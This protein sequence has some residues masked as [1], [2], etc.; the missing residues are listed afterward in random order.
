[1]TSEA[2]CRPP[3]SA[4]KLNA[5]CE[6]LA[7]SSDP[8]DLAA[9][10]VAGGGDACADEAPDDLCSPRAPPP[11]L[12][13]PA[14][15]DD[16]DDERPQAAL[17]GALTDDNSDDNEADDDAPQEPLVAVSTAAASSM[18]TGTA[19]SEV[20]CPW[21]DTESALDGRM[22]NKRKNF[23]PKNIAAAVFAD[24]DEEEEEDEDED[25][26]ED[27][28]QSTQPPPPLLLPS[29]ADVAQDDDGDDEDDDGALSPSAC[30][31][32][33]TASSVTTPP[34]LVPTTCS[35]GAV[36][37]AVREEGPLDLSDCGSTRRKLQ[38]PVKRVLFNS[39]AISAEGGG[40]AL[41]RP[42][43]FPEAVVDLSGGSGS[44]GGGGGG[45]RKSEDDDDDGPTSAAED[46]RS[47]ASLPSPLRLQA[48][49]NE[50][51]VTVGGG[52]SHFVGG[53]R[54]HLL[55]HHH[56]HHHQH[57]QLP[58][59]QH[60]QSHPP[61][62][63]QQQQQPPVQHH[64]HRAADASLM[65]DYAENTMKEL[66]SMYGLHDV[67]ESITKHVPLH[68]FS[69]G[70]ILE[71]MSPG[72]LLG[73]QA[74]LQNIEAVAR[75]KEQAAAAACATS[76]HQQ[77]GGTGTGT[78]VG[79]GGGGP[80]VLVSCLGSTAPGPGGALSAPPLSPASSSCG[81]TGA[82]LTDATT[83][84]SG[85]GALPPRLSP[86]P[87]APCSADVMG[88]KGTVSAGSIPGDVANKALQIAGAAAQSL[89]GSHA[90]AMLPQDMATTLLT[91]ATLGGK[92]APEALNSTLAAGGVL[93]NAPVSSSSSSGGGS[94]PLAA[95]PTMS[96]AAGEFI[97]RR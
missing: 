64:Q 27:A 28:E 37:G 95:V 61:Q 80:P 97:T 43:S 78:M 49:C 82:S 29:V 7:R 23:Q 41:P 60:Q 22:R 58:P 69:S 93:A 71:S 94:S 59:H 36:S 70:N 25:E 72:A 34:P 14:E 66:L 50:P 8:E 42:S 12:R 79:T 6:K 32:E 40:L 17:N 83:A 1:M 89:L 21:P 33:A 15:E 68:H 52:S 91:L 4:F 85:R 65:K 57:Q 62:Q 45:G 75:A 86:A 2:A 20:P 26:R 38:Q 31:K 44:G 13:D 16:L 76:Q 56:H 24:S 47:S 92:M 10:M 46:G 39:S 19:F 87:A 48:P 11:P 67:V 77:S 54:Q 53:S 35:E 9:A 96:H 81:S 63:Q 18:P 73:T 55:H 88:N 5:I 30:F 51:P 74:F 3:S 84:L 90:Q